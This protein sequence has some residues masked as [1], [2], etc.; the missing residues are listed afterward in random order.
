MTLEHK[1]PQA[2]SAFTFS[3][4]RDT[5]T[6]RNMDVSSA[7]PGDLGV[8]NKSS[9]SLWLS[10]NQFPRAQFRLVLKMGTGSQGPFAFLS[11]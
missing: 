9:P 5:H 3:P 8:S 4:H 2:S 1:Q 11:I 10:R 6:H 7:R